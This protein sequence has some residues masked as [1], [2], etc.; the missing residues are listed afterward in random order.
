MRYSVLNLLYPKS[1]DMKNWSG[2]RP[3]M[4]ASKRVSS[5]RQAALQAV[6]KKLTQIKND[7]KKAAVKTAAPLF[8][9]GLQ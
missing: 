1:N 8:R 3:T 6:S 7:N 4:K 2:K 9:F 5:L